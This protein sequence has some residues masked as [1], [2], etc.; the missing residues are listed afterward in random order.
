M[1][2][3]KETIAILRNFS[4]INSNIVIDEGSTIKTISEAKNIFAKAEINEVFPT[5][6]GIY[7][8]TEFLSVLNL[9]A[10]PVVDITE[11]KIIVSEDGKRQS[12]S[13]TPSDREILTYPSKDINMPSADVEFDLTA[14]QLATLQK[15]AS[16]LSVS[17][18]VITSG[19]GCAVVSVTDLDNPTSN[20]YEIEFEGIEVPS[21]AKIVFNINNLKLISDDYKVSVS[22]RLISQFASETVSYYIALEKS[23]SF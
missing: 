18:I 1:K 4:T 5:S 9:F 8:L 13:Y 23:S 6:F 21:D 19:D 7:D 15:A 17:D 10:N 3:S 12:V 16:T 14:E 11:R 2:L 22:S 20:S